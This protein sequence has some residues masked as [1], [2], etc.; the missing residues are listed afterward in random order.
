MALLPGDSVP[1]P[2]DGA[3]PPA[4]EPDAGEG[5]VVTIAR[6]GDGTYTVYSG[7]EPDAGGDMGAA[8]MGEADVAAMGDAGDVA[9]GGGPVAPAAQGQQAGSIGAAL[10]IAMDILQQD[11]GA[12]GLGSANDQ[13]AAGYAADRSPTPA[14]GGIAQKY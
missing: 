10:K 2:A 1:L 3:A 7:D 4:A 6:N 14:R 12:D 8:D 9:A 5:V 13:F 11:E